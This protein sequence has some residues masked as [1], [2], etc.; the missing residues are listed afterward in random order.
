MASFVF[1]WEN[2]TFGHRI[3]KS[4][5]WSGHAS[6]CI[7]E[8]FD[9]DS[10]GDDERNPN[11]VSWWPKERTNFDVKALVKKAIAL[12]KRGIVNGSLLSDIVSCKYLPDHII[13]LNTSNQM[14]AKMRGAWREVYMKHKGQ[15]ER[16]RSVFSNCSTVVSRVLFAAGLCS[17]RWSEN[18]HAYW[19]PAD[20]LTLS[21]GALEGSG[22]L[23][24]WR[25]F[26][27]LQLKTSGIDMSNGLIVPDM[28]VN[29]P[30]A[31]DGRLCST[32]A[33]C[34]YHPGKKSP[35]LN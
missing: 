17:K 28:K 35:L 3:V 8:D 14:D 32:G 27:S 4:M 5:T 18:H 12:P 7:G 31:R 20:I 23:L 34:K 13:R 15:G 1:V 29:V 9:L 11:F 2:N 25:A 33:P 21:L 19:T 6:M 30:Q 26:N 10:M 24:S 22:R 16:Y